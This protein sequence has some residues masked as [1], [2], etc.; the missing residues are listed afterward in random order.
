MYCQFKGRANSS[1]E[2]A[3][4]PQKFY[5]KLVFFTFLKLTFVYYVVSMYAPSFFAILKNHQ[6]VKK[7]AFLKIAGRLFTRLMHISIE[8]E[9]EK[10]EETN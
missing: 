2:S 7:N 6:S 8:T 1:H 4:L 5:V 10:E 9:K 3:F